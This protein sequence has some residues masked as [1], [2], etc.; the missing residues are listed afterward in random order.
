[1][2][3]RYYVRPDSVD[4]VRS[5]WLGVAIEKYVEWLTGQGY[6]ARTVLRRTPLLMEFGEFARQ[7]G[8]TTLEQLPAQ[9][10]GFAQHWLGKHGQGCKTEHAREKVKLE[11]R[12]P[13]DQMLA[14]VIPGYPDQGRSRVNKPF[15]D[16]VPGFL[17]YL[18]QER[19]LSERSV[20]LYTATLR[21]FEKYGRD[22]GLHELHALSPVILSGF[23]TERSQGL[24]QTSIKNRCG[25][26][27]VFLR[28]LYREH[29]VARD[30]GPTLDSPHIYRLAT[31]PRSITWEEVRRMLDGVDRRTPGGKRD[32]AILLLL[33]TYGLRGR[34]IAALTLDD[35]DWRRERL[36][37]PERKADHSTAYPLSPI[38]GEAILDYLQ[39]GRPQT[40]ERSVFFRAVAPFKPMT[41]HG[42][43]CRASHYLHKAGI[44]VS[45]PGSHTL[46]HTCVQRLVDADFSLKAIGDYIGH[47][48]PA[49]TQIYAKVAVEALRAVGSC[50]GEDVL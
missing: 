30:L 11:A 12:N 36:R 21:A 1:M 15:Q 20:I 39:H 40:A 25:M 28:Y 46:R 22:I 5:S 16:T 10:D 38:V 3:E 18:R 43:S 33:V 47:T 44:P 42:V 48:S 17:D 45:R 14:L 24:C 35:I 49:S 50:L 34:E 6:A 37:V 7:R 9:V 4:R 23:V 31:I 26:L 13:V 32:Y 2:L 8:V 29:I 27:R 19:G 41:L